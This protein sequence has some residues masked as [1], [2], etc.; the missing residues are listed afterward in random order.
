MVKDLFHKDSLSL[1]QY[2]NNWLGDIQSGLEAKTMCKLLVR[3]CSHLGFPINHKKSEL[4]PTQTFA[5]MGIHFNPHLGKTFITQKNRTKVLSMVKQMTRSEQAPASKWQ[6][7]IR[8]LQVQ[9]TL[10][11]LGRLKVRIIYFH[12][13]QFWNQNQDPLDQLVPS[14]PAVKAIVQW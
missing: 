14:S 8:T 1:F 5:F 13:S 2:L 7:V 10:I 6:S 12:L 9:A 11:P 4:K 3:L